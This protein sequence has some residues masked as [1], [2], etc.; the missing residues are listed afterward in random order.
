MPTK[1]Y[2]P[3]ILA[4]LNL[5]NTTGFN[6]VRAYF[7][8]TLP[9][10]K[11]RYVGSLQGDRFLDCQ[12]E[13]NHLSQAMTVEHLTKFTHL[14]DQYETQ[15][16][17]FNNEAFQKE[18]KT[19]WLKL[20]NSALENRA[21]RE[22]LRILSMSLCEAHKRIDLQRRGLEVKIKQTHDRRDKAIDHRQH[23]DSILTLK[24]RNKILLNIEASF[25]DLENEIGIALKKNSFLKKDDFK[26]H[27]QKCHA[28]FEDETI[29]SLREK[30]NGLKMLNRLRDSIVG[31]LNTH[32]ALEAP[33]TTEGMLKAFEKT[34][35]QMLKTME[36]EAR[37]QKLQLFLE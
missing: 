28:F 19:F 5:L 15:K 4:E 30:N 37:K 31:F 24:K 16:S 35:F 18:L 6:K 7:N 9:N 20:F 22:Q 26:H 34:R 32:T 12:R 8:R 13:L 1:P 17:F 33:L 21:V 2:T 14:V 3:L 29:Q 36:K 27:Y 11:D 25:S 23:N 10:E